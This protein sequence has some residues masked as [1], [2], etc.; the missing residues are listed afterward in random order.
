M[1]KLI[2]NLEHKFDIKV[3]Y[4]TL[5]GSYLFGTNDNFSDRDY[6]GVFISNRDDVLLKRDLDFVSENTNNTNTRNSADDLDVHLDSL[7]TWLNLLKKG[8]TGA[9]DVLFSIWDDSTTVFIDEDFKQM[10]QMN[11]LKLI[12]KNPQAFVGYCISQ[13]KMYNVKGERYDELV[14]L[15]SYL[16]QEFSNVDTKIGAKHVIPMIKNFIKDKRFKYISHVFAD[17]PHSCGIV[18]QLE[19]LDILGKR[20]PPTASM[21]YVIDKIN[22]LESSY[23]S[24]ARAAVDNIDW[25]ALSHALRV[26]LE[27]EELIGMSFI[28]FPLKE[29][30]FV[31]KVKKG[32]VPIA[33]VMAILDE[34]IKQIDKLMLST[35]LAEKQDETFVKKLLLKY[36]G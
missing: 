21:A 25:K 6:K 14:S 9:I 2:K 26:I 3:L 33:E 30:D 1:I 29:R 11:Y 4:L 18:T 19:Y 8:E 35:T 32:N 16:K 24:R 36:Y 22:N 12:S 34:K 10:I 7:H 28:T 5:Y 20:F 23:G 27:V 13:C 17:G 15:Q 31:F